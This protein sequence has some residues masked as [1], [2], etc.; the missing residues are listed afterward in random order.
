MAKPRA[1]VGERWLVRGLGYR[2][3]VSI[4]SDEHGRLYGVRARRAP[5]P[6]GYYPLTPV[7]SHPGNWG[8]FVRSRSPVRRDKRKRIARITHRHRG[9]DGWLV[10]VECE[11]RRTRYSVAQSR[12]VMEQ[13][14]GRALRAN[15]IVHHINRNGFDDRPENLQLTTRRQHPSLHA[16]QQLESLSHASDESE[17]KDGP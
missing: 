14:L 1:R 2:V 3:I 10:T 9:R 7:S 8:R 15:E 17:V 11:G 13:M 6:D 4:G 5:Y 12:F 16:Q